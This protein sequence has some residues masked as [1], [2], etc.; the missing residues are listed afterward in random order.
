[1]SS[2]QEH[3]LDSGEGASAC[4]SSTDVALEAQ[5]LMPFSLIASDTVFTF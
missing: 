5:I 4:M 3:N 2:A 1:M